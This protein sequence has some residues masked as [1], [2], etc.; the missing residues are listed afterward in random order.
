MKSLPVRVMIV[1]PLD[2]PVVG[3][4]PA[5]D[6]SDA[7]VAGTY[8]VRLFCAE[9]APRPSIAKKA[10]TLLPAW[11]VLGFQLKFTTLLPPVDDTD[12]IEAPE[13]SPP[14]L[15]STVSHVSSVAVMEIEVVCPG[16]KHEG[17]ELGSEESG[18]LE[19]LGGGLDTHVPPAQHWELLLHGEHVLPPQPEQEFGGAA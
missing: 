12:E 2:G 13:G 19:N 10:T 3:A 11:V 14:D 9:N 5:T 4:N 1:P 18:K 15:M 16:M 8:S 7:P 6:G 17:S